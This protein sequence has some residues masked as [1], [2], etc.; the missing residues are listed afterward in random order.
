MEIHLSTVIYAILGLA[1]AAYIGIEFLEM[2]THAISVV[3]I[4]RY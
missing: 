4:S 1:L 3:S 2:V